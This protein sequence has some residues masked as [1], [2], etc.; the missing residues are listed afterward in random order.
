MITICINA[1]SNF[2][3]AQPALKLKSVGVAKDNTA[4]A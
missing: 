2:P 4:F 1:L 3:K